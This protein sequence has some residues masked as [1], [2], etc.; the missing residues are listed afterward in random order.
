MDLNTW[1]AFFI[2]SCFISIS[3]GP[4]AISCMS[5]GMRYGWRVAVWNI[6]GLMVGLSV[7]VAIIGAGVGALLMAS[8]TAFTVLKWIGAAYLVYLGIQQW[9]APP[10]LLTGTPGETAATP[11]ELFLRGLF[12]NLTNPKGIAFLLA[13][14]PQF[15]D[16]AKPLLEQYAICAVTLSLTDFMIM[17]IY[18]AVAANMLR[19]LR[20]ERHIRLMNRIF[21]GL[22]VGAGAVLVSFKRTV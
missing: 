2:A 6:V 12:V 11:H 16:P 8:S 9:R 18:T 21:G 22:F 13:V 3:P 15:I 10:R 5:A 17:N 7:I 14:L 19:W 4:G 1:I 20:E